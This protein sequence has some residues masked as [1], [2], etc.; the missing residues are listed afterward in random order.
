MARIGTV[1]VVGCGAK[2]VQVALHD[3]A[4]ERL[5]IVLQFNEMPGQL[6]QQCGVDG[7]IGGANV[8]HRLHDAAPEEGSPHTVHY[9]T[10][11]EG[12]VRLS[13]PVHERITRV[14]PFL[15]F[16]RGRI[17]RLGRKHFASHRMLHFS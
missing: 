15:Q 3:G 13:H 9:R 10:C 14:G 6:F 16:D 4:N 7:R 8:I 17:R 1:G 11:K 12:I 5:V 2:L